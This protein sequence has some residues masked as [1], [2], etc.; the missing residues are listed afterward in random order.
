MDWQIIFRQ[1]VETLVFSLVGLI[2][3]AVFF[4]ILVRVCP[5]SIR[6]EIEQDQN[7][8]LGIILGAAIIGIA[9]IIASAMHG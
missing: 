5:F 2:V 7:T 3:C 1:L 9:I 6:K 4:F 8:S